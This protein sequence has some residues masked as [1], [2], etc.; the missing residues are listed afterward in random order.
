MI[1]TTEK[2]AKI[3]KEKGI[4]QQQMANELGYAGISGY[5][6]LENGNV[7]ITLEKAN[8][9]SKLLGESIEDIFFTKEVQEANTNN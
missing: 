5:S 1:V 9:I 7:Q 4:T 3:R 2:L 8:C 6:M